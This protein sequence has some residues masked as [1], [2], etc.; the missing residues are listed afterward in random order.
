MKVGGHDSI[1]DQVM[2]SAWDM[3]KSLA[4]TPASETTLTKLLKAG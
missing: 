1:D 4:A 3:T 2:P